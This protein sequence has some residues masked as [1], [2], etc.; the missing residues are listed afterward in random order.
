MPERFQIDKYWLS[1]RPSSPTW[2]ATWYDGASR[3]TRRESLGVKCFEEAKKCLAQWV[4]TSGI[5]ERQSVAVTCLGDVF[6]RYL[7]E[8]ATYIR[9]LTEARRSLELFLQAAVA[10]DIDTVADLRK[11]SKQ[12]SIV[13][14]FTA[15]QRSSGYIKR[16][17]GVAKAAVNWA[18][19][20]D[21]IDSPVPFMRLAEDNSEKYRV[22]QIIEIKSLW[23]ARMPQHIRMFLVLMLGTGA[24][25]GAIL[26][27][28]REACNFS[29]GT[30]NLKSQTR[31]QTNK[32]RPL[33]PMA[34]F[35]RSRIYS[36]PPGP[37]VQWRGGQI[38]KINKTWRTIREAAGLPDYVVPYAIRHTLA[39]EMARRGV[40]SLELAMWFGHREADIRTTGRYIHYRPDYLRN[41]CGVLED[42][43]RTIGL[44]EAG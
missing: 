19:Q 32:R 8:H 22:L 43:A 16:I 42:F 40:P 27:L 34:E 1:Q 15:E 4:V 14:F 23:E 12:Q 9:S 37:L 7:V 11:I 33:L 41:A 28:T 10:C 26:D 2:Y 6:A 3:Q 17:F 30:I 5:R 36:A 29:D 13:N 38:T 20:N 44:S 21:E 24:R 18:W 31:K 39:T 25:P 35:L